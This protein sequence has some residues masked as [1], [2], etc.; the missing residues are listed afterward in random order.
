MEQIN[1]EELLKNELSVT[2]VESIENELNFNDPIDLH[3]YND[4][5]SCQEKEILDFDETESKI[6]MD[7]SRVDQIDISSDTADDDD[8]QSMNQVVVSKQKPTKL[9]KKQ[10][11][12]YLSAW[13]NLPGAYYRTYTYNNLNLRQEKL[14]CWLYKKKDR[15]GNDTLRCKLCEKYQKTENSNGKP[16]PWCTSGYRTMRVTKLKE[17][18]DNEVHQNAQRRELEIKSDSQP[19]WLTTQ[20]KERSKHATAIQNLILPAVYLCQQDQ[21]INSFQKLCTLLEAVDV[22]LLPAELGGLSYRNDT[23]ALEFLYHVA[24]YLHGQI[25]KKIKRSPSIGKKV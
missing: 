8:T 12:R 9:S 23:A 5:I 10:N 13:E 11:R 7:C 14:I 1:V 24:T 15:S 19:S 16:N 4:K 3:D 17:H 20:I 25:V 18:K 22:K 2:D 6:M 21:S